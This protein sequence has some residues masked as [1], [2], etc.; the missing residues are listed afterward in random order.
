MGTVR[1][2]IAMLTYRRNAYLE[3]PFVAKAMVV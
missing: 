3:E 2:T 1:L